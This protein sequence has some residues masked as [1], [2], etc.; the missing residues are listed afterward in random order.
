M[1]AGSKAAIKNYFSLVDFFT[2]SSQRGSV[3]PVSERGLSEGHLRKEASSILSQLRDAKIFSIPL[4]V[5]REVWCAADKLV[6]EQS[7]CKIP[8][9]LGHLNFDDIRNS[10][11]EDPLDPTPVKVV[12]FLG[13]PDSRDGADR[14]AVKNVE[15]VIDPFLQYM[16]SAWP[17]IGRNYPTRMPFGLMYLGYG[18]GVALSSFQISMRFKNDALRNNIEGNPT[19]LPESIKAEDFESY[20]VFGHLLNATGEAWEL[21]SYSMFEPLVLPAGV[22]N[23]PSTRVSNSNRSGVTVC[24]SE[25]TLEESYL[26]VLR[27]GPDH[28]EFYAPVMALMGDFNR[29]LRER[30]FKP[31]PGSVDDYTLH[32]LVS[33]ET[34]ETLWTLGRLLRGFSYYALH[35]GPE[36]AKKEGVR[37][38]DPLGYWSSPW[39]LSPWVVPTLVDLINENNKTFVF[40]GTYDKEARRD[41]GREHKRLVRRKKKRAVL[42][43]YYV[44]DV[45]PKVVRARAKSSLQ[46]ALGCTRTHT[47]THRHDRDGHERVLVKRGALPLREDDQLLLEARG[48]TLYTDSQPEDADKGRLVRRRLPLREPGEWLAMRTSWVSEAVVGDES[49]PYRPAVRR[50]STDSIVDLIRGT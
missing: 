24:V 38:R 26:K 48:Y 35:T 37:T 44:I 8:A 18:E 40:N 4:A 33:K 28:P 2:K 47:L 5:H 12:D 29:S 49:L 42:P 7:G 50:L 31:L 23:S 41:I 3:T 22:A 6:V 17:D 20:K 14:A 16:N 34:G 43:A 32:P 15:D 46:K 27:E 25:R 13:W 19:G 11:P 30:G 39:S 1:D 36:T 45:K 9:S 21:S 10:F